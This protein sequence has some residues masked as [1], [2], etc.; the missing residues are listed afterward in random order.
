MTNLARRCRLS[1]KENTHDDHDHTR[2][3]LCRHAHGHER[4][5]GGSAATWPPPTSSSTCTACRTWR[6]TTSRLVCP[7]LT[8][9][10]SSIPWARCTTRSRHPRS[11]RS[12]RRATSWTAT[13]TNSTPPGS[14]SM[15][16]STWLGTTCS[17]SYTPTRGPTTVWPPLHEGLLPLTPKACTIMHFVRYHDFEGAALD[18]DERE[19][20]VRDLGDDGHVI[21]LRNHGALSVGRTISEAWVWNYRLEM[22]CRYRIRRARQRRRRPRPGRAQRGNDH[23]DDRSGPSGPLARRLP[24]RRHHRVA[25]ASPQAGERTGPVLP[26]LSACLLRRVLGRSTA[27]LHG[28]GAAEGKARRQARRRVDGQDVETSESRVVH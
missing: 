1:S 9:C 4:R 15:A 10:S 25:V 18:L 27:S 21:I 17:A 12:I 24:R 14:L 8:T 26:D 23:E 11:S 6:R 22:A 3:R 19:R 16:P 7:A 28:L 2:P 20:L 13:P 5:S